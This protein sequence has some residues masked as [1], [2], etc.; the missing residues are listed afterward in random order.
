M[1]RKNR[2]M[3]TIYVVTTRNHKTDA[4]STFLIQAESHR[5]AWQVAR[6][7]ARTGKGALYRNPHNVD[8]LLEFPLDAGSV[9]VT[10]VL[11]TEKNRRGRPAKILIDDLLMMA[12]DRGVK[13]PPRVRNVL[14]DLHA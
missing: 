8:D 2:V 11:S 7:V 14:N 1:F 9:T 12:E 4:I 10:R 6:T 5:L 3:N 13:I